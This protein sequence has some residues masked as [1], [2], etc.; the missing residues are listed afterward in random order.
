MSLNLFSIPEK[1]SSHQSGQPLQCAYTGKVLQIY[2][3]IAISSVQEAVGND[4]CTLYV[5][6]LE[7][8]VDRDRL[9]AMFLVQQPPSLSHYLHSDSSILAAHVPIMPFEGSQE[10][11][12]MDDSINLWVLRPDATLHALIIFCCLSFCADME[13]CDCRRFH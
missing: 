3:S 8:N 5:R 4:P 11:G 13:T 1:L 9:E 12:N 10:N 7:A 6:G 2:G